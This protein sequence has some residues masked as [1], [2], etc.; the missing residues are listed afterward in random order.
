MSK[1][2]IALLVAV[3]ILTVLIGMYVV[4]RPAHLPVENSAPTVAQSRPVIIPAVTN[5]AIPVA[6]TGPSDLDQLRRQLAQADNE[7][8]QLKKNDARLLARMDQIEASLLQLKQSEAHVQTS[9]PST[10]RPGDATA[11]IKRSPLASSPPINI[12]LRE[13]G[14]FGAKYEGETVHISPVNFITADDSPIILPGVGDNGNP[15]LAPLGKCKP[16]DWVRVAVA[17]DDQVNGYIFF[18]AEQFHQKIVSM[19]Q[20]QKIGLT[21]EIV[22]CVTEHGHKVY[23]MVGADLDLSPSAI[24][25]KRPLADPT[26]GLTLGSS[27]SQCDAIE[28]AKQQPWKKAVVER[29]ADELEIEY[30]SPFRWSS[31]FAEQDFLWFEDGKLVRIKPIRMSNYGQ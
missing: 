10:T 7:V 15:D 21:G 18:P 29:S 30:T 27:E 22:S 28:S 23:A 12:T 26:T 14:A 16:E 5:P 13:L 19:T 8:A 11:R 31:G 9:T 20:G 24:P 17:L 2:W 3:P 1:G 25:G 6:T 4:T